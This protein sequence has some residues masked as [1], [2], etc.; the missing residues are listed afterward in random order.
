MHTILGSLST[1][2]ET[3]VRIDPS[4]PQVHQQLARVHFLNGEYE[5]ALREINA[6]L[7][8]YPDAADSSTYYIRGLIEGYLKQ[9]DAAV[10]DYRRSVALNPGGWEGRVDLAWVLIKTEQYDEARTVAQDGLTIDPHN[11]W[12]QSVLATALFEQGDAEGALAMAR[13]AKL[14]FDAITPEQWLEAYPGNSPY[15]ADVG[16]ATLREAAAKNVKKIEERAAQQ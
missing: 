10:S 5:L 14:G 7:A 12:L 15:A 4:Y 11:P 8:A 1:F 9:Y 16:I 13:K 6:E 2:F 3:A